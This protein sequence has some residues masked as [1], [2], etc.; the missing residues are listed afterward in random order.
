[1][2][3]PV[4]SCRATNVLSLVK[5]T[6]TQVILPAGLIFQLAR[7]SHYGLLDLLLLLLGATAYMIYIFVT[8]IWDFYGYYLR[9]AFLI[10]HMLA[11]VWASISAI[12]LPLSLHVSVKGWEGALFFVIFSPLAVGAIRGLRCPEGAIK[13]SFPFRDGIYYVANG[14]SSVL[15]NHH[16]PAPTTGFGLDVTKLN[17]LGFRASSIYPRNLRKYYVFGG[18]VYSPVRGQVVKAVDD[19]PDLLPP[20]MDREHPYGNHVIIKCTDTGVHLFLVHLQQNSLLL[21]EGDAVG[22]GQPIGKVGNS[23]NSTEPHLHIHAISNESGDLYTDGKRVPLIFDGRFLRR[24][25]VI[26]CKS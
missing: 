11:V 1:M 8:G 21:S 17:N 13:V 3:N 25:S 18:P 7:G 9:Y 19:L 2:L 22:V 23:G 20:D 5:L 26:R 4:L 10:M 14:G 12:H 16:M 6:I 15:I 24:N